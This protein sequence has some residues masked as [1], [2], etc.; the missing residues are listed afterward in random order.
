MENIY[1]DERGITKFTFGMSDSVYVLHDVNNRLQLS[2]V[3]FV[4]ECT[5]KRLFIEYKNAKVEQH[6]K[7]RFEYK[8][9]SGEL[10]NKLIRKYWDSLF[11]MQNI[12]DNSLENIYEVILEADIVDKAVRKRLKYKL[13]KIMLADISSYGVKNTLLKT[14]SVFNID[15]WKKRHPEYNL[16]IGV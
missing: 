8:L 3:D 2:D 9:Q 12:S 16:E 10:Q 1:Y 14:V 4:V 7:D 6:N 11:L 13:S 15:N 5:E